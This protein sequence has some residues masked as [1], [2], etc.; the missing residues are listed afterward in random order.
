MAF[1]RMATSKQPNGHSY[2]PT[3]EE[4]EEATRLSRKAKSEAAKKYW[5]ENYEEACEIQRKINQSDSYRKNMS[6]ALTDRNSRLGSPSSTPEVKAKISSSLMGHSVSDSTR[7][8]IRN[9][10]NCG[11]NRGKK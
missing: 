8:K 2:I 3:P 4:Y 11:W 5:E 1:D 7:E 6:K 10:P 9:N